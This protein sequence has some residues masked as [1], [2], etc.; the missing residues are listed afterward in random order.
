[1]KQ[2]IMTSRYPT[3][4]SWSI[5]YCDYIYP[6]DLMTV[7]LTFLLCQMSPTQKNYDCY[8]K[9]GMKLITLSYS[10]HRIA[11]SR[12]KL[13]LWGPQIYFLVVS[14]QIK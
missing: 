1:V 12:N 8:W 13:V 11:N 10:E 4:F 6:G 14:E 7:L 9:C 2:R 5:W 3:L